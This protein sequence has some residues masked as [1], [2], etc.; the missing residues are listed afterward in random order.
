MRREDRVCGAIVV[1]SYDTPAS[2][3]DEDRALLGYVAQH[4]L[5]AL[6]R[7]HAHVDLER[8][9]EVRTHELQR[10]N[11]ELQAEVLERKRAEKLQRA[12][13]RIAELAITS[14]SLERF[15]ADVHAVVDELLYARNFY[16]ALLSD[17]GETLDFPYSID[18]RDSMRLS[19]KL[20]NGLTEHV[21]SSRHAPAGR[22]RQAGGAGPAGQGP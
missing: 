15:Y 16:I 4:I 5:T 14:E 9:I 12:L 18:E 2:Y 19:R 13:F 1:Q 8:R 22:S 17:D 7:K 11:R 21:I 10:A 3:A 20:T 6:D